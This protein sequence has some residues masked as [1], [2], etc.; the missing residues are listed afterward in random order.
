MTDTDSIKMDDEERN[1]FLG[2][3]GTGVLSLETDGG[4]PPHSIPVSY[5][6]DPTEAAFYFRLS[7]GPDRAKGELPDRSVT[8]VTYARE[9]G[10]WKSVVASGRLA[11]T[12][13]ESVANETLEG[14]DRVSNIPLVDIFGEPT[15][16]VSF[17]FYYLDPDQLTARI[18]QS[19]EP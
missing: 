2:R 18:E 17:E 5:G 7:A 3:S 9:D 19:A 4:E 16:Q 8:F 15:S 1:A 10:K 6:Y 13:D 14:L 11:S 12:T